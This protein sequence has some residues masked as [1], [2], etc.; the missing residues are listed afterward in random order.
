MFRSNMKSE[1]GE[2]WWGIL[3]DCSGEYL[4]FIWSGSGIRHEGCHQLPGASS[5]VFHKFN[6][7][8]DTRACL[9]DNGPGVVNRPSTDYTSSASYFAN[10]SLRQDRNVLFPSNMSS[11]T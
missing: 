6:I 8:K 5:S 3:K 2:E 1:I 9:T 10:G 4:Y 11:S 7:P